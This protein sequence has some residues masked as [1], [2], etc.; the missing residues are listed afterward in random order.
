MYVL[1]IMIYDII[2]L[3][4]NNFQFG[5]VFGGETKITDEMLK[6]LKEAFERLN[7]CLEG[8]NYLAGDDA[9]IA[10]IF[11]VCTISAVVVRMI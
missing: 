9:T 7:M 8:K 10:D 5:T 3:Y 11:A 6:G 1:C 4:I 2:Y